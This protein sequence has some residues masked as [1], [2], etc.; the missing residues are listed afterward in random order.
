MAVMGKL[1]LSQQQQQQQF[2]TALGCLASSDAM[3]IE[4]S[5]R[6]EDS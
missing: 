1:M 3:E 2:G 5:S 4:L 6:W